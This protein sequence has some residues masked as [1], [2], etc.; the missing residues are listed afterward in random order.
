MRARLDSLSREDA[1]YVLD[2]FRIRRRRDQAALL[3]R[4]HQ[5]HDPRLPQSP[6]RRRYHHRRRLLTGKFTAAA[7]SVTIRLD[8]HWLSANNTWLNRCQRIGCT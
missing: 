2:T 7:K 3:L 5:A 6:R 1:A 4:P 8:H